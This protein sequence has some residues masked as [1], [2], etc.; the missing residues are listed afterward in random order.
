MT[1]LDDTEGLLDTGF[2]VEGE[3]GVDLGGDLAG[4][5]LEDLLAELDKEGIENSIDLVVNALAIGVLLAVSDSVVNELGIVGLLGGS[6]DQGRVGGSI[7]GL[8]L[9]NGSKVTRVADDNLGR[10]LAMRRHLNPS[11]GGTSG[12]NIRCQWP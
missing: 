4:D 6:Q 11:K 12:Q 3:S 9:V 10:L 1:Y 8:V 7:L 2:S 5:N